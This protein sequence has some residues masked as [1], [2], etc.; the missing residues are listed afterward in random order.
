MFGT[1]GESREQKARADDER[2]GV[3]RMSKIWQCLPCRDNAR[4]GQCLHRHMHPVNGGEFVH[5]AIDEQDWR[6]AYDVSGEM[7]APDQTTGITEQGSRRH[8]AT[9]TDMSAAV[10]IRAI[11]LCR[12]I[13]V[14]PFL[15][16]SCI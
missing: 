5:L 16:Y 3:N 4:L 13:R 14:L 7:F 9:Q 11:L 10:A 8:R 12:I 15:V 2:V 6:T 1:I